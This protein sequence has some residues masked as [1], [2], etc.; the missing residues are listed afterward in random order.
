MNINLAALVNFLSIFALGRSAYLT[1]EEAVASGVTQHCS[2][3]SKIRP[4][5]KFEDI[6]K[7]SVS[8]V[9]LSF[10]ELEAGTFSLTAEFDFRWDHQCAR[11]HNDSDVEYFKL[12]IQ[13]S[14]HPSILLINS[15]YKLNAFDKS[16]EHKRIYFYKDGSVLWPTFDHFSVG[17]S[18]K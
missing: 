2:L 10:R 17:C 11:W 8:M 15:M 18:L 7:V 9:P 1:D 16:G 12:P 3:R 13:E 6:L 4:L 14:W 5:A